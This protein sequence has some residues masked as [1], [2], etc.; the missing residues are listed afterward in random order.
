MDQNR[1]TTPV[2]IVDE[3]TNTL[4]TR[5]IVQLSLQPLPETLETYV[6]LI[7]PLEQ[8]R[9]FAVVEIISNQQTTYKL[10]C[11]AVER[12]ERTHNHIDALVQSIRPGPW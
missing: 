10:C 12:N 3:L 5:N 8:V 7:V 11:T 2:I 6:Y 9:H 1:S 4:A